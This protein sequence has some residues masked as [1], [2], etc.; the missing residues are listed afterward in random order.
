MR[1]ILPALALMF[2]VALFAADFWKAKDP[3][4]WTEEEV[5]K[6]LT[7]SPWARTVS[8]QVIG[9]PPL[10]AAKPVVEIPAVEGVV[11]A[12]AVAAAEAWEAPCHPA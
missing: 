8:L 1:K 5:A 6:M 7:K 3:S 2:A 10:G 4:Q 12:A 11:A 9:M